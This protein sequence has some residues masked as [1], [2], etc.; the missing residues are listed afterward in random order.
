MGPVPDLFGADN[1]LIRA[2]RR[3]S[4]H[5]RRTWGVQVFLCNA[6][7]RPGTNLVTYELLRG[8]LSKVGT[9]TCY[10]C[11][12]IITSVWM[13]SCEALNVR[14]LSNEMLRWRILEMAC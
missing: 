6:V 2:A 11:T 5:I 3:D 4:L 14:G 8:I 7:L 12:G 1:C 10:L 13:V 9:R